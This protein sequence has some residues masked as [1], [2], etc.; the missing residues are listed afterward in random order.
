MLDDEKTR[1]IINSPE[2][3]NKVFLIKTCQFLINH[4]LKLYT[5]KKQYPTNIIQQQEDKTYTL[6][7]T[8][9]KRIIKT[10][11]T[12]IEIN[13]V[14]IDIIH[15]PPPWKIQK[16]K[17]KDKKQFNQIMLH[18]IKTDLKH[19]KLLTQEN[20]FE[21]KKQEIKTKL[22]LQFKT[23]KNT[24][25]IHINRGIVTGYNKAFII[26][27][28]TRKQLIK[29]DPKNEEIIKPIIQ[30]HD[31]KKHEIQFNKKYLIFTKRG[32]NIQ[33]YPIIEKYLSKYKKDL[34]PKPRKNK[35]KPGRSPRKYK[36]YEIQSTGLFY[37]DFEKPKIIYPTIAHQLLEVYD[38]NKY[39]LIDSCFMITS[40]N[41]KTLKILDAI[42]TTEL[43]NYLLQTQIEHI[44]KRGLR[45]NKKYIENIPLKIPDNKTAKKI[46]HYKNIIRRNYKK[47]RQTNNKT[48]HKKI[49][50]KIQKYE[51]KLN[52]QVY[53]IYNLEEDEIQFI[54]NYLEKLDEK[55]NTNLNTNLT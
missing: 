51:Q 49:K 13:P 40:D 55:S 5:Q 21:H 30:R 29:E 16:N 23:L 35:R 20:W 42:L 50:Q 53:N 8:E 17:D 47:L 14:S 15:D 27:E 34:K 31:I 28:K 10:H 4:Y 36:W 37:Q 1:Q 46:I 32:I 12:G 18:T 26:D 39:Y 45:F 48:K 41:E 9:K 19:K 3:K 54:K 44:N 24:K 7:T 38:T 43:I 52:N 2:F 11:K 25:T 6:T 22:Q 33:Q